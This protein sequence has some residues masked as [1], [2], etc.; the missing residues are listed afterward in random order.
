M[1]TPLL[2]PTWA[3]IGESLLELELRCAWSRVGIF[4]FTHWHDWHRN[5]TS[6][7]CEFRVLHL[8]SR[9]NNFCLEHSW[10]TNFPLWP[11]CFNAEIIWQILS[12]W[13][14]WYVQRWNADAN[15]FTNWLSKSIP[16]FN[17]LNFRWIKWQKIWKLQKNLLSVKCTKI[18]K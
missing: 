2:F 4:Y 14:Y 11:E 17:K 9:D 12:N 8:H 18:L 16:H 6:P 1:P 7:A 13:L 5:Y 10:I 3:D 15:C